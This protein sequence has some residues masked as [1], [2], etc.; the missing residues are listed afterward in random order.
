MVEHRPTPDSRLTHDLLRG[1]REIAEFVFGTPANKREAECNRQRAYKAI[2][3]GSLPT[4]RIGGIIH[5]RKSAI[6]RHI[7]DQ[8]RGDKGA[9]RQ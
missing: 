1:A 9:H 3:S 4:F 2:A 8:E 7:E 5:A 6:L